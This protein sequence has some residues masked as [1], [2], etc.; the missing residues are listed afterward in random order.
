MGLRKFNPALKVHNNLSIH[1]QGHY[2]KTNPCKKD[3]TRPQQI[4][5]IPKTNQDDKSSL[6]WWKKTEK[7]IIKGEK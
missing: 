3:K 1:R 4:L 5:F 7:K 6:A 2:P